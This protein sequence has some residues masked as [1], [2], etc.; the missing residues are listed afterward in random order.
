MRRSTK[1]VRLTVSV[2]ALV[3]LGLA[4]AGSRTGRT[5]QVIPT[6]QARAAGPSE[7]G[8]HDDDRRSGRCSDAT[9]QGTYGVSFHGNAPVFGDFVAVAVGVYDGKGHIA[10]HGT[11]NISG[12]VLTGSVTGT[13]TVQPDCSATGVITYNGT[14]NLRVE[15]LAVLTDSGNEASFIGTSPASVQ[16]SGT[17]KRQ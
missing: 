2:A 16:L 9:L 10:G 14:F 3:G 7:G 13:Y 1:S 11:A 12:N 4:F 17:I 8:R 15:G 6:V 5:L